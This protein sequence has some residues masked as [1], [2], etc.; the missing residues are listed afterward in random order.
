MIARL[1]IGLL[2][3]FAVAVSIAAHAEPRLQWLSRVEVAR[4][5]EET[6]AARR[7]RLQAIER[8]ITRAARG[9]REL[10]AMLVVLGAG[11]TH[12]GERFG[13]DGCRPNECDKGRAKGYFQSHRASCGELW[14]DPTNLAIMAECAARSLR[15]AR[16]KCRSI[17]GAFGLYGTG[18]RCS[19][20]KSKQRAARVR[21]LLGQ[22]AAS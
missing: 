17:E 12:F 8:A 21:K 14:G 7:Q 9:D 18:N 19:S 4:D 15:Y 1:L 13:R 3:L 16:S 11:E 5:V 6:P 22:G 10:V 2:I 20:A